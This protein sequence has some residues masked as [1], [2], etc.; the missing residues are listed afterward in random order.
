MTTKKTKIMIRIIRITNYLKTINNFP[1]NI[2]KNIEKINENLIYKAP[3][4]FHEY[5]RYTYVSYMIKKSDIFDK[6]DVKK[7]IIEITQEEWRKDHEYN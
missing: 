7:K 1:K 5:Y 4:I 2:I 3:E 6:Y